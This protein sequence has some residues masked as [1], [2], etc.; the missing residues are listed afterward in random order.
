MMTLPFNKNN[1]N[2]RW[3]LEGHY[4]SFDVPSSETLVG[5]EY[6]ALGLNGLIQY[7]FNVSNL[8]R[9]WVGV[10]GGVNFSNYKNRKFTDSEGFTIG[11]EAPNRDETNLDFLLNLGL[12]LR[13]TDA[14]IFY[15]VNLVHHITLDNGVDGTRLTIF[16]LF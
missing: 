6:S 7:S 9:P 3:W 5:Q 10:G 8:V 12:S 13:K 2:I 1:K 4:R 11:Q 15:G 14:G 16:A